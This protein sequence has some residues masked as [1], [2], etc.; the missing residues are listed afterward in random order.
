VNLRL[1]RGDQEIESFLSAAHGQLVA[2]TGG[3]A[4]DDGERPCF[5]H[6]LLSFWSYRFVAVNVAGLPVFT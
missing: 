5:S 3:S 1:V 4:R 6:D 2:D